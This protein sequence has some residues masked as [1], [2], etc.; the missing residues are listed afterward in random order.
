VGS[1]LAGQVFDRTNLA[2]PVATVSATDSTYAT[3]AAGVIMAAL[4]PTSRIDVTSPLDT[5]WRHIR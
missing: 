1:S 2:T 5:A 4:V 3:D